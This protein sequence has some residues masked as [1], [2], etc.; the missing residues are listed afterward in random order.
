MVR[1]APCVFLDVGP[2]DHV[3]IRRWPP[4]T[5]RYVLRALLINDNRQRNSCPPLYSQAIFP[6]LLR[7]EIRAS[8]RSQA[9]L[10]R[11]Y[12]VRIKFYLS[13]RITFF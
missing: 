12:D 1:V 6:H 4:F 7:E 3:T 11:L 8:T 10:A 5:V 9:G 13:D 2:W